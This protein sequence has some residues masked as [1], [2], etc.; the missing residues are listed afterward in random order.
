MS[1][2]LQMLQHV[3]V[4]L[5]GTTLARNI[6]AAARAMKVMGL[7]HLFLVAPKEFPHPDASALAA[8]AEDILERAV[9]CATLA[10][11]IADCSLVFGTSARRRD[12]TIRELSPAQAAIEVIEN[13][14]L[15]DPVPAAIVFGSERVGL[16][17]QELALCQARIQIPTNADY[18]SL[19]LASAVQLISYELRLAAIGSRAQKIDQRDLHRPAAA[20]DFDRLIKHFADYLQEIN[21]YSDKNPEK[22]L[23]RLRRL[24]QRAQP[25]LKEVQLLR[26]ILSQSSHCMRSTSISSQKAK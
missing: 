12:I 16:D 21:F 13:M 20:A 3:R 4:V 26:G 24:L 6:G 9:L 5:V 23:L 25:D 22:L 1:D 17:N 7:R 18:S 10:D 11:A 8:G 15:A 19:N 14:Q 2:Q